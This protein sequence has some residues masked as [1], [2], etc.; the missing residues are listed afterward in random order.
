MPY[1]ILQQTLEKHVTYREQ[2]TE[3]GEQTD[4][5]TENGEQTEKPITQVTVIPMNRQVEQA[6]K[7]TDESGKKVAE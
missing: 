1:I 4:R 7:K 5:Q 6:N 2:R 3:N